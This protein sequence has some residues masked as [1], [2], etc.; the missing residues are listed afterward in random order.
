MSREKKFRVW[1]KESKEMIYA[2]T[3]NYQRF[4]ID[5]C[6]NLCGIDLT[7]F[8]WMGILSAGR[9]EVQWEVGLKDKDGA[10]IYDGDIILYDD[11]FGK[12]EW[13]DESLMFVIVIDNFVNS[14]GEFFS[15]EL[16]IIGNIHE[17]LELLERKQ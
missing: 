2:N 5:S 16:E 10:E 8:T 14:L 4:L 13:C 9:Y 15:R 3:L 17:N 1:D 12:I 6:G 11:E 7:T